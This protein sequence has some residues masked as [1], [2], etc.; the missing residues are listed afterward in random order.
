[1]FKRNAFPL[2]LMGWTLAILLAAAAIPGVFARDFYEPWLGRRGLVP[3]QCLVQDLAALLLAP[4]LALAIARALRGSAR[5]LVAWGGILVFSLY[6]Y[7]FYGMDKLYT[8]LYPAY[9][10]I[11]GLGAW[12]LVALFASVDLEAFA[13]RARARVRALVPARAGAIV[14]GSTLLFIPIWISM[15]VSGIR[16]QS[17]APASTVFLL[18]LSFLIPA[19]LWTAVQLWKMKPAG[20]LAGGIL[21]FKAAVSGLVLTAGSLAMTAS[22]SALNIGEL[23]L[24]L[25]LAIPG[26]CVLALFLA[27]LGGPEGEGH[28][29]QAKA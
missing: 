21:L 18:D 24:Y 4:V 25:L 9:L 20:L 1:M 27:R 11:M 26:G 12:S 6:Y 28:R 10:A 14:L 3:A 17:V 5:A 2:A 23:C 8:P 22:G 16:S 29:R 15:L 19:S 7:S 13:G